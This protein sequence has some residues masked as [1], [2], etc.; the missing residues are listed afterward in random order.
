MYTFSIVGPIV[1]VYTSINRVRFEELCF[2]LFKGINIGGQPGG[3]RVVRP[4]YQNMY[5][6]KKSNLVKINGGL[7][8]AL[9]QKK[10]FKEG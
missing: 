1:N 5:H 10:C 4:T 8:K 9:F 2:D 6:Q 7:E 3:T